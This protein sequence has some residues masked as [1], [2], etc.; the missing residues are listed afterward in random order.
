MLGAEDGGVRLEGSCSLVM[1][2]LR[3]MSQKSTVG[4]KEET[5]CVLNR[6]A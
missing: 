4:C 2:M 1:M 5:D 3:V 6:K